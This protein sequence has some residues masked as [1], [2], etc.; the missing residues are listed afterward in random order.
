MYHVLIVFSPVLDWRDSI[1][2]A[3][4]M[5]L[6]LTAAWETTPLS[7]P[8]PTVTLD[9]EARTFLLGDQRASLQS[10]KKALPH[11]T[12]P[13]VAGGICLVQ[14]PIWTTAQ[15][16]GGYLLLTWKGRRERS[17][18]WR[19]MLLPPLSH[20]PMTWVNCLPN[21]NYLPPHCIL[22]LE[23]YSHFG[24]FFLV[25]DLHTHFLVLIWIAL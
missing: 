21:I 23:F 5:L 19:P 4:T 2:T 7:P 1:P 12:L 25:W 10:T 22:G 11:C 18:R 14:S 8:L 3:T 15:S 17:Q 24:Y 6:P 16:F 9:Q 13:Q 20:Q